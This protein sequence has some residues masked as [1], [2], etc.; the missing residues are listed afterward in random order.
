M[1]YFVFLFLSAVLF[2]VV[3]AQTREEAIN[4]LNKLKQKAGSLEEIILSPNKSDYEAASRENAQVF[5]I[6]PRETYDKGLFKI[7]GG[8]AFYSFYR[9][10]HEYGQG[11]DISLEQG[12][13]GVGFAGADYGFIA[14][15]G[16]IPLSEINKTTKG[17]AYLSGYIPPTDEADAR[18][19]NKKGWRPGFEVDGVTYLNRVPAAAGHTYVIRSVNLDRSDV[20]VAFRVYRKDADRSYI[21]FWKLLEQFEKPILN[22]SNETSQKQSGNGLEQRVLNALRNK[23]F[24]DVTVDVS[25]IPLTLRGTVPKGKLA[26][27]IM[28]A[29]EEIGGNP[30]KNEINEK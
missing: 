29:M 3:P 19:E 18:E 9:Q 24:Y 4:E 11:S 26:N 27:A 21:I 8:G 17:V 13:F 2:S 22:R 16:D 25:T 1:R 6:L 20:L 14:D 23:G 28:T 15:L 12:N 30:V 5:R 10:T 7:R